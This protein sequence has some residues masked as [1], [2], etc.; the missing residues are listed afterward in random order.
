MKVAVLGAGAWG[1]ALAAHLAVRH[2]TLLWARDAALVAELAARRENAR[3]LG[4]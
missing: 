3:Y 1:T 2:D 4:G